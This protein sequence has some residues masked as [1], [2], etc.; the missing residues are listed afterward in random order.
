MAKITVIKKATV[1]AKP[2]GYCPILVD[3]IPM[4][5]K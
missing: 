4:T 3:D 1:N 2:Q 5:K